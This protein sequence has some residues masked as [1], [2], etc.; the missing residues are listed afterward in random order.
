MK[1]TQ[2]LIA[3]LSLTLTAAGQNEI[4]NK[5]TGSI[6]A[7]M[8]FQNDFYFTYDNYETDYYFYTRNRSTEQGGYFYAGYEYQTVFPN[9]QVIALEPKLGVMLMDDKTGY[10]AGND[11]KCFWK[12]TGF[13]KFGMSWYIGYRYINIPRTEVVSLQDGMYEQTLNYEANIHH[14][15]T[16]IS[17]IPFQFTFSRG[18][19]LESHV[20]MGITW[21]FEKP[22]HDNIPDEALEQLEKTTSYPYFPKFGIKLGYRLIG[23][24]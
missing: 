14:I 17:F 7:G 12:N 5:N 3:I 10:L 9:K 20:G 19:I 15:D 8:F 2:I 16:D 21:R 6:K 11:T 1:N 13:Y 4:R 23:S 24:D 18:F 22:G